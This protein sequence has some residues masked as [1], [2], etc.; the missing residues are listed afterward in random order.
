MTYSHW[1]IEPSTAEPGGHPLE[2]CEWCNGAGEV[3]EINTS[4]AVVRSV[5]T[6]CEGKGYFYL[7]EHPMSEAEYHSWITT[8]EF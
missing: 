6:A 3:E 5:C 1:G 8:G 4:W 2:K 7:G